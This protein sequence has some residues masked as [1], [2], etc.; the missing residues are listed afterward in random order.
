[1][2]D[3]TIVVVAFNLPR[4]LPRTLYSLSKRYQVDVEN[5]DYNVLVV[6]NGSE[7]P[8]S[9]SFVKQ[10]GDEFRLLSVENPNPSPVMAANLGIGA[11]ESDLVALILDG[12]RMVTPGTISWSIRAS[13]LHP[14]PI[15]TPLAWHLGP[16]HQ[17]ISVTEGYSCSVEDDLLASIEWKK[18]G[19]RLFAISSLAY[20]NPDGIFHGTNES[21]F[22]VARK[23]EILKI[24][25]L[26][27]RFGIPGGGFA[28]LDFFERLIED[29][30]R[31]LIV[32]LGEGTFH[33][34]HNRSAHKGNTDALYRD[35]YKAIRGRHYSR[36]QVSPWYVGHVS[37]AEKRWL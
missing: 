33:Q 18:N 13:Q 32:I 19:Y 1:M 25:G 31:Q 17:S 8:I 30:N 11:A 9:E 24:G 3:L 7:P 6:D 37:D 26:E 29:S 27:T 10:F 12:A 20:A 35:N 28:A 14:R 21:T 36:P 23:E 4:E 2:A 16:K 22:L 5:V 15:I 34:L